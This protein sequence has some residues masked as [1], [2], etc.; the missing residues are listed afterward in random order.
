[1]R[2]RPSRATRTDTLFAD[3]TLF[4]SRSAAD[5]G[6]HV[7]KVAVAGDLRPFGG[8]TFDHPVGRIA[9]RVINM[10]G[11][12]DARQ[13]VVGQAD[14]VAPRPAQPARS[15]L[16]ARMAGVDMIG[17]VQ[18]NGVAPRP[19]DLVGPDHPASVRPVS[20]ALRTETRGG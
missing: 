16:A 9:P 15:V 5:R 11:L 8:E 2:L 19:F 10:L 13:A 18:I 1:M 6:E 3:T 20:G 17:K 12:A 7:I 4:R 14:A